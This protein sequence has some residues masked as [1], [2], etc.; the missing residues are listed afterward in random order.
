MVTYLI[1]IIRFIIGLPI[2]LLNDIYWSIEM[3]ENGLVKWFIM[4]NSLFYYKISSIFETTFLTSL[5]TSKY[6][7]GSIITHL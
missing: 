1:Y 3:V 4:I 2:S 6:L 7:F 5:S